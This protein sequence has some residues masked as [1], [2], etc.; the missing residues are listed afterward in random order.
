MTAKKLFVSSTENIGTL[1]NHASIICKA[2]LQ[3][4][5]D[6]AA[7]QFEV[8][9]LLFQDICIPNS[10][11]TL[12]KASGQRRTVSI[13]P[14]AVNLVLALHSRRCSRDY[15]FSDV[16]GVFRE[17]ERLKAVLASEDPRFALFE[18]SGLRRHAAIELYRKNGLDASTQLLGTKSLEETVELCVVC[19][20]C[21]GT[22]VGK[23]GIQKATK[24]APIERNQVFKCCDCGVR[25]VFAKNPPSSAVK[26]E[27]ETA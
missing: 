4:L 16:S 21:G 10:T 3:I 14:E 26:V 17:F 1:I 18:F 23:S 13:S 12:T 6:T 27:V 5:R 19:P 22:D 20:R 11:V 8:S 7:Q 15:V 25:F 24:K 2:Y 9:A